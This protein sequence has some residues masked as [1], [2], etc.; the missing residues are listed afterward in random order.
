MLTG[1]STFFRD[2]HPTD[3]SPTRLEHSTPVTS[4]H[5]ERSAR[6]NFDIKWSIATNLSEFRQLELDWK[7]LEAISSSSAGIFL[8]YEWNY[9]WAITFLSSHKKG[10]KSLMILVGR[11]NGEVVTIWPMQCKYFLG[12]CHLHWMGDPVSQYGDCLISPHIDHHVCLDQGFTFLKEHTIASLLVLRKVRD[13]SYITPLIRRLHGPMTCDDISMSVD[14]GKYKDFDTYL[15]RFST[16][17]KKNRRRLLR[18]LEKRG[19]IRFEVLQNPDQEEGLKL[20][21]QAI[22]LKRSWILDKNLV[23]KAFSDPRLDAFFYF[24]FKND[25]DTTG[26]QIAVLY[27]GKKIAAIMVGF[28]KSDQFKAHISVINKD[29]ACDRPG[30]ALTQMFLAWHHENGTKNFDFLAPA[31]AY[32]KIW[33]DDMHMIGDYTLP[34]N[35]SG[36]LY[37]QIMLRGLRQN[38]KK[39]IARLPSR[40]RGPIYSLAKKLLWS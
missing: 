9:N 25:A 4:T 35:F 18:R 27:C 30:V 2:S 24:L 22:D 14:L 38:G 29:F 19:E 13:D 6:N 31:D 16:K 5:I 21:Q 39:F 11:L 23:S 34:L 1:L 8:T 3:K 12:T 28:K 33:T 36:Y 26:S 37:T 7:K 40:Y 20:V 15:K 10:K 32:K 17:E